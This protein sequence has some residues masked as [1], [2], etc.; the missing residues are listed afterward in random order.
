MVRPRLASL[1]I[2]WTGTLLPLWYSSLIRHD[3]KP[4]ALRGP[5]HAKL[6]AAADPDQNQ[7]RHVKVGVAAP[8]V[9]GEPSPNERIS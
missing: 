3:P 5:R 2:A 7:A 4:D 1:L 6:L 8:N 9:S